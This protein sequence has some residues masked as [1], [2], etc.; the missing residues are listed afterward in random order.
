MDNNDYNLDNFEEPLI[1]SVLVETETFTAEAYELYEL[2][3]E[4]VLDIMGAEGPEQMQ[5]LS[6][7]FRLALVHP[8][9]GEKL[10]ILSFNELASAMF[11]WYKKSS[12]RISKPGKRMTVQEMIEEA[13]G[14]GDIINEVAAIIEEIKQSHAT[15]DKKRDKRFYK[16]L[17]DPGDGISPFES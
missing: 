16:P 15:E 11:Q 6:A 3:S 7:A 17:N 4:I 2:P 13:V 14:A 12:L 8:S 1:P 10:D 5:Y 9:D